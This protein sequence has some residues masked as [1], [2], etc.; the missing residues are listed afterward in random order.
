MPSA[1]RSA[2]SGILKARLE[3]IQTPGIEPIRMLPASARSTLPLIKCAIEATR[4]SSAAWKTS[5]PTTRSGVSRKT[6]ISATAI[7]APEPKPR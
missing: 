6:R 1:G 5:V 7:G 2:F 3:P 4:S